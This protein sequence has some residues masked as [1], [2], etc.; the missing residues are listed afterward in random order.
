MRFKLDEDIPLELGELP[1]VAGHD[2]V[3]V[4]DQGLGSVVDRDIAAV[5]RREGRVVITFDTGF[6]DIRQYPPSAYPGIV[7]LRLNNQ[8]REH[9]LT[10]GALLLRAFGGESLDGQLWI[11]EETRVRVRV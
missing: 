5:C 11:V 1:R 3:T 4:L 10:I 2:A 9:T 7:V 8:S 6:A